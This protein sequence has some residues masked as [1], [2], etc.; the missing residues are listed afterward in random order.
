MGRKRYKVFHLFPQQ[1]KL[2]KKIVGFPNT[3]TKVKTSCILD[4]F[5]LAFNSNGTLNAPCGILPHGNW[6]AACPEETMAR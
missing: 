6:L 1:D 3:L 4:F 5:I 2:F